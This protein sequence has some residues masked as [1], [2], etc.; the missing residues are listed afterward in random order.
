MKAPTQ[1]FNPFEALWDLK[2]FLR[3]YAQETLAGEWQELCSF[4]SV[5]SS[6]NSA[7]AQIEADLENRWNQEQIRATLCYL[8]VV[9][10]P[11]ETKLSLCDFSLLCWI[12]SPARHLEPSFK[13]AI[14]NLFDL[15]TLE[16]KL[17]S[18]SQELTE[19]EA[20][21]FQNLHHEIKGSL[22]TL[23]PISYFLENKL[24]RAA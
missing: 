16:G 17:L 6:D 3:A 7:L 15:G 24:R 13:S 10:N 12:Q 5:L 9:Q 21:R 19:I 4:F 14:T 22:P 18:L 2:K 1:T 8:G 20:K 23:V 11:Q